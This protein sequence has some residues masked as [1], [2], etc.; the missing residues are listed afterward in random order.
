MT[1]SNATTG[2]PRIELEKVPSVVD[3][4]TK[5]AP[6]IWDGIKDYANKFWKFLDQYPTATKYV[7]FGIALLG[8]V[9][10]GGNI[11]DGIFRNI[12]PKAMDNWFTRL[13]GTVF[14]WA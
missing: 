10:L 13:L 4:F 2:D 6:G 3:D 12:F 5:A 7:S 11:M 14:T 8:S 1:G 9:A